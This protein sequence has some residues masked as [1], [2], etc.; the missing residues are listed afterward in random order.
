MS[1]GL[2]QL[3]GPNPGKLG[4]ADIGPKWISWSRSN[5]SFFPF[6]RP[7]RVRPMQLG[8]SRTVP[9]QRS[10]HEQW[11]WIIIHVHCSHCKQRQWRRR[12]RRR[13]KRR[14]GIG[15]SYQA[16]WRSDRGGL[17]AVLMVSLATGVV[18][19]HVAVTVVGDGVA[20]SWSYWSGWGEIRRPY[21]YWEGWKSLDEVVVATAVVGVTVV[22][23][24]SFAR[25]RERERWCDHQVR[26]LGVCLW[27]IFWW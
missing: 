25:E 19:S 7:G 11:T 12:R 3:T 17:V 24:K 6:F 21:C 5:R 18:A 10:L 15:E 26:W 8:W 22:E 4:W 1:V 13:R 2:D 27:W 9:T 14:K 20:H 16:R 23:K